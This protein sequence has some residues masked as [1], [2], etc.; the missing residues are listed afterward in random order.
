LGQRLTVNSFTFATLLVQQKTRIEVNG[1]HH[2][3]EFRP[4][5]FRSRVGNED[6]YLFGRLACPKEIPK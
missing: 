5:H 1:I 3:P 2:C 4:T 6:H